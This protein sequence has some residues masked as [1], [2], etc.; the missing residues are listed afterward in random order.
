MLLADIQVL[1]VNRKD[2]WRLLTNKGFSHLHI[3]DKLSVNVLF[4][5]Y[6]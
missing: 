1:I 4:E 2:N 3:I 5:R 6:V